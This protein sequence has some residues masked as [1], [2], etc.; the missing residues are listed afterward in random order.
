MDAARTTIEPMPNR[1]SAAL[2][3]PR[4]VSEA[5]DLRLIF[6]YLRIAATGPEAQ[7][8]TGLGKSTISEVLAGQRVRDTRRRPHVALVAE[9]IRDLQR[10]RAAATGTADRR[11]SAA[12]WLHAGRVVT[13]QGTLSPIEV[14][15]DTDLVR[16]QLGYGR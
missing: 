9:L 5:D 7:R 14:L 11:A 10:A 4:Y 13:Q 16:E 12:G 1:R 6:D 15:A 8:I 3:P 2:S